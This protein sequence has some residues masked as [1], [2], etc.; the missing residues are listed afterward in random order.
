MRTLMAAALAA[1]I[2]LHAGAAA[3]EP[4]IVTLGGSITEIA[5]ALGVGSQVV[6]VDT[7]S[8]HPAA[9]ETL[10]KVGYLRTLSAEGIL[11]LRPDV[12][13]GLEEAGPPQTLV[14]LRDSG[15]RLKLVPDHYT[16]DGIV[17]KI[18]LVA[19]LFGA[20]DRGNALA[21]AVASD[22]A[23][24]RG[25][26]SSVRQRPKVL[27]LLAASRGAPLAAGSETAAEAMIGLA[28]GENAVSGYKGYKPLSVEAAVAFA[29]DAIVM[30]QHSL[31][32]LGGPDIVLALPGIAATPAGKARRLIAY[33]GLYLLGFGPRTAHAI[34]DLAQA[35][36]PALTLPALPAR[37]WASP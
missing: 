22:L 6:A 33:D 27:F 31:E 12:V 5:Y 10:P 29:P 9:V 21:A 19:D 15:A 14:Q 3:A 1:G 24:V 26:L 13:V 2:A 7:T 4:R 28:G 30:M 35:L 32:A 18:H 16:T 11:S 8:R 36:H 17:E 34:R 37:D 25:A 23:Q 20:A